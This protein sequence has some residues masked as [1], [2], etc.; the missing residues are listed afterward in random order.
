M[1]RESQKNFNHF[2]GNT[3]QPEHNMK[4]SNKKIIA[5]IPQE[6]SIK[7]TNLIKALNEYPTNG[8]ILLHNFE[9]VIMETPA[10]GRILCNVSLTISVHSQLE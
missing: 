1:S 5:K 9:Q 6:L 10:K 2:T 8:A 7:T 3:R 4:I